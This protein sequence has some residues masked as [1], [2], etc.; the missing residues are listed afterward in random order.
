MKNQISEL[1]SSKE[2]SEQFSV[3]VANLEKSND[4]WEKLYSELLRLLAEKDEKIQAQSEEIAKQKRDKELEED[5]SLENKNDELLEGFRDLK[6]KIMGRWDNAFT[7]HYNVLK[8]V[9]EL[10]N[11]S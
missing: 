8:E 11:T 1:T 5:Y 2:N 9:G 6:M 7:L 10:K 3:K 4:L